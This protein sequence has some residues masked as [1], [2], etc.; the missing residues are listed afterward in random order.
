MTAPNPSALAAELRSLRN[1]VR[2]LTALVLVGL[3][4]LAFL[5]YDAARTPARPTT[6][7]TP[8]AEAS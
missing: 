8:T 4:A 3:A 6:L 7:P 1:R 5:V 2:A